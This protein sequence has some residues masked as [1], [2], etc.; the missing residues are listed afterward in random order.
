MA[1]H[2]TDYAAAHSSR[3]RPL[4][5]EKACITD[6]ALAKI[7]R[8]CDGFSGRE[9]SKLFIAAQHAMLLSPDGTLTMT[10]LESVVEA[11]VEEH[12]AKNGWRGGPSKR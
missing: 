4:S 8:V 11:K 3:S 12:Q 2:V 9:I 6:G 5:V 1:A 7:A 10:A